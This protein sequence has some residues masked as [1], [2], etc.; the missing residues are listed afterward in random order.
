M[1]AKSTLCWRCQRPGTNTCSWDE[2]RGTVPVEGWTAEVR[3]LRMQIGRVPIMKTSYH[4]IACP[5]YIP[6]ENQKGGEA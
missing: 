2:S 1:E 5:L 6:D 3:P 4:V